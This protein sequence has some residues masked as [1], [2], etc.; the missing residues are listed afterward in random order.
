MSSIEYKPLRH[1]MNYIP[2]SLKA[3]QNDP[4][5]W[6]SWALQR[7]RTA[8]INDRFIHDFAFIE[9]NN[10]KGEL[11][12]GLKKITSIFMLY[13]EPDAEQL[14]SLNSC[15]K[16]DSY[17][18]ALEDDDDCPQCNETVT[19]STTTE[20]ILPGGATQSKTIEKSFSSSSNH[21]CTI[22][23]QLFLQSPYFQ[24][25][26]KPMKFVGRTGDDYFTKA[27][28]EHIYKTYQSNDYNEFSISES[29]CILTEFESGTVFIEYIREAKDGD[30][31]LAP[32]FPEELWLAMAHYGI[33]QHW[34]NRT[35]Y[36]EQN[37]FQM[38][39]NHL[40]ISRNYMTQAK[41][42]LKL[43]SISTATQFALLYNE[44]RIMR[45]PSVFN[46]QTWIT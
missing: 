30:N 17:K 13:E 40:V 39:Q 7:L 15:V 28:F 37:S 45:T 31:F 36:K 22:N 29:G 44:S 27:A 25:C 41:G 21:C 18:D 24:E 3:E 19:E 12:T 34:L 20:T 14:S 1:V 6:Q 43:R 4:D 16:Y 33:A 2:N 5:Q 26:W 46:N 11:P 35:G 23:Y 9:I 8:E 42:I 32:A 10:H 38:Y